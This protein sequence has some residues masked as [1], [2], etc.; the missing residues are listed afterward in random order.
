MQENKTL[1]FDVFWFVQFQCFLQNIFYW[2]PK[3]TKYHHYSVVPNKF[4]NVVFNHS[5]LCFKK[6]NRSLSSTSMSILIVVFTNSIPK[7]NWSL[8]N[9][10]CGIF[11][12]MKKKIIV[13]L[14][15]LFCNKV[16]P[17]L[18]FRGRTSFESIDSSLLWHFADNVHV[19]AFTTSSRAT[20]LLM[21]QSSSPSCFSWWN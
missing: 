1:I 5:S 21:Q 17:F 2:S 12:N 8:A 11:W 10:C 3:F 14:P 16:L 20:F 7:C 6:S 4:G 9:T 19:G 13:E 18:A 15:F